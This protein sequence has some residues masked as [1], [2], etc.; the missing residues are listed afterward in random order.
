MIRTA[1][2]S[3]MLTGAG[4]CLAGGLTLSAQSQGQSGQQPSNPNMSGSQPGMP[5]QQ[6]GP[7]SPGYNP[8][9]TT[10]AAP[11]KVDDKKFLKK[12]AEGGME[13]VAVGNL[14]AQKGATPAVRQFGQKL[15]ADH[16]KADDQLKQVA[17]QQNITVPSQLSAKQQRKVNKLAKLSG[18]KFDKAFAKGEVKDHRKDIDDFQREAQYGSNPAVK[19]F[20]SNTLPVL[21]QHLNIAKSLKTSGQATGGQADSGQ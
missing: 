21:E 17:A 14:A 13:E 8:G 9:T 1:L 18:P 3:L 10:Q 4:L 11:P 19:Q 5:S 6:N 2:H 20:A 7:G 15:A 16:T 12:A